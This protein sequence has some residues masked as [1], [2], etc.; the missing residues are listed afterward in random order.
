MREFGV[1]M[2]FYKL[3]ALYYQKLRYA[4]THLRRTKFVVNVEI[5]FFYLL[6]HRWE[7][8]LLVCSFLFSFLAPLFLLPH[9]FVLNTGSSVTIVSGFISIVAF[10]RFKGGN[11]GIKL[12]QIPDLEGGRKSCYLISANIH[13]ISLPE[14]MEKFEI[15]SNSLDVVAY[16]P[17]LDLK[18]FSSKFDPRS[19]I[20]LSNNWKN[21]SGLFLKSRSDRRRKIGDVI[22]MA[23]GYMLALLQDPNL[24]FYNSSLAALNTDIFANPGENIFEVEKTD[25]FEFLLTAKASNKYRKYTN[26][27]KEIVNLFDKVFPY[28]E[29][30]NGSPTLLQLGDSENYISNVIGVNT[31]AFTTDKKFIIWRQGDRNHSSARKLVPTGSGSLD[32]LDIVQCSKILGAQPKLSEIIEYGACRELAE[33]NRLRVGGQERNLDQNN[34]EFA[35]NNTWVI[36]GY[37]WLDVG[38]KPDF[39]SV[40]K[41]NISSAQIRPDLREVYSIHDGEGETVDMRIEL[42]FAQGSDSLKAGIRKLIEENLELSVPLAFTLFRL[43]AILDN[44]EDNKSE[45]FVQFKKFLEC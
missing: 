42:S 8:F 16:S 37:R 13:N 1:F 21:N 2:N 6:I 25:Y 38:A 20:R 45:S 22:P 4:R 39:V 44:T 26:G 12:V 34:R 10:F 35:M 7:A 19:F 27:E 5:V 31:L 29:L 32:W 9:N 14:N 36:G 30:H 15:R 41:L 3:P 33:E 28:R 18:L 11:P 40:T 23:A 43:I 24:D 17:K